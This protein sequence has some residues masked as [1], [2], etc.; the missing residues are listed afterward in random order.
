MRETIRRHWHLLRMDLLVSKFVAPEPQIAYRCAQS[1]K[2][3]LV[4]SHNKAGNR[5]DSCKSLGTFPFGDCDFCK[6]IDNQI[7]N[8]IINE[9][10]LKP[11]HFANCKT[12]GVIYLMLCKFQCFYVRMTRRELR[13][14]SSDQMYL[15]SR[16]ASCKHWYDPDMVKFNVLDRVHT[17][18]GGGGGVTGITRSSSL[19]HTGSIDSRLLPI[20]AWTTI[21]IINVSYNNCY[22]FWFCTLCAFLWM[23]YYLTTSGRTITNSYLHILCHYVYVCL[24]ELNLWLTHTLT[25]R[26]MPVR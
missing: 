1:L 22:W 9:Q 2:D 15:I 17:D 20:L 6:F 21:I 5:T 13:V 12:R 10:S 16:H 26:G 8:M 23:F 7:S 24:Y 19:K 18:S 4:H 14:R 25:V 11:K 3:R